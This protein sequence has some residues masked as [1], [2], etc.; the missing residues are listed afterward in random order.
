MNKASLISVIIPTY[1][2]AHFISEAIESVLAQTYRDFEIVVV[3]DGSTDDTQQV[4]S[5]F[6]QLRYIYQTNKGIAAARNAGLLTSHGEYVV[7][8]D[9]DDRL[10]S[11]CLEVGINCLETNRALAF[12]SGQWEKITADGK[13]LPPIPAICVKQDHYRAFLDF[14]YIGTVGQVMF[15]RSVL[16]AVNGFDPSVPGCDDIE[17]YLRISRD[18]PVD[19]HSKI[20]AQHRSHGSN[21]SSNRTMML[22]SMLSVYRSQWNYVEG[23]PELEDLCRQGIELCEKFLAKERRRMAHERY[24]SNVLVKNVMK[25]RHRIKAELIVRR[26]KQMRRTSK[27]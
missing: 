18:Y 24:K 22:T 15:R 27:E 11:N 13:A 8:L 25:L 20:V 4:V 21:T 17:L 10:S 5:R 9:A 2:Y 6:P 12:V 1:N 19:C 7:F 3:D 14:N 23:K 16:E 26:Y